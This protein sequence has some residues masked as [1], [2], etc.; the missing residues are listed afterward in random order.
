M[1]TVNPSI[2]PA[3]TNID[4]RSPAWGCEVSGSGVTVERYGSSGL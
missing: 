4:S 1:S 2:R 3:N